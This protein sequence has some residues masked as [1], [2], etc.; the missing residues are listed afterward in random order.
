MRQLWLVSAIAGAFALC[1]S[2]L[3]SAQGKGAPPADPSSF[4]ATDCKACH[5]PAVT[6][7]E[8]T[9]HGSVEQSCATCHDRAKAIQHSKD[10][11]DGKETPGPSVKSLPA[12]EI[13][14]TC[15]S[16]HEKNRQEAFL[17]GVHERRQVAC[18]NCH[19][20]HSF[21]S[22]KSQLKTVTDTETCVGCHKVQKA[23]LQRTA[24]H[25]L[26]EGKMGCTSCHNP[27]DGSRPKMLKA[28]STNELCY[29]CHTEK[30]GPFLYEHAAVREDCTSCHAPHGSNHERMLIAK[31]PFLCQ[32]CHYSGHGITGDL[33][34]TAAG[35]PSAPPPVGGVNQTTRS[36]RQQERSCKQCH[37]AIHGSNAP[38]GNFFVR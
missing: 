23:Q 35:L 32:R 1:G 10:R 22:A 20:I 7:L 21:K 4:D 13:V 30:R 19:S 6:K 14:A 17:G 15:L 36:S 3:A 37:L 8:Q 27:H 34:N 24:H 18:T 29:T 38:S 12:K 25:P 11:A 31:P 16:C 28:E 9:K 2:D 26:R 33:A 5:E